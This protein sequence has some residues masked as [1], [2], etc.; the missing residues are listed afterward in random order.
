VVVKIEKINIGVKR[1]GDQCGVK[2]GVKE[3]I[4]QEMAKAS[5]AWQY[6]KRNGEENLASSMKM[7]AINRGESEMAARNIRQW[8]NGEKRKQRVK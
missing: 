7:A 1:N 6:R 5:A 8:R 4:N 3:P 2:A